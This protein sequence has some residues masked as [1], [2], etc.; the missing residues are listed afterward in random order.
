MSGSQ[1]H[2]NLVYQAKSPDELA[3]V[4]DD[5]SESYDDDLTA[6]GHGAP[7]AVIAMVCRHVAPDAGP[8]L[9][10][11]A[12]TGRLGLW[13]S[14]FGYGPISGIDISEG[15]LAKAK[16][17]GAYA[18]L[19]R[20]ALG[21]RLDFSDR[22]FATAVAAGV[23]TAG[24]APADCFEEICRVVRP[25]GQVVFS[26]RCDEGKGE[27]YLTKADELEARGLWRREGESAVY[28]VFAEVPEKA[29]ITNQV[30]AYR[31]V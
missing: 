2:L 13:L 4:Y 3:K 21:E 15:M 25:G 16:Q 17:R 7:T 26:I 20:M 22:A 10:C 14:W 28:P 18:S 23:F 29:H 8:L 12:G 11:G 31:L 9:D 1:K 5:W 19:S 6:L 27:P 24:H 30:L